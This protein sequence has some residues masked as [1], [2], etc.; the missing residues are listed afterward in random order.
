M[1]NEKIFISYKRPYIENEEKIIGEL[2]F[3]NK[4]IGQSKKIIYSFWKKRE[5]EMR[6]REII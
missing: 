4:H 6:E 3:D 2:L 1:K 5:K